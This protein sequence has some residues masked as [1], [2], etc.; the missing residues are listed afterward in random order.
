MSVNVSSSVAPA[1][2]R[3]PGRTAR[4][5]RT[6][7]DIAVHWAN[8]PDGSAVYMTL[9]EISGIWKRLM[10]RRRREER[11]TACPLV[12]AVEEDTRVAA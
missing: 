11:P 10:K 7:S 1:R 3:T 9:A 5:V 2:S 4:P 6:A 12:A 8:A